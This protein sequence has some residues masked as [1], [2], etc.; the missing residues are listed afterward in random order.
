MEHVWVEAFV[1]FYPMRGAKHITGQ[2]DSWIPLDASFKQ[3]SYTQG[4]DIKSAV[5]FD[6]QIFVNQ[7]QS[8]ATI[9]TAN[10]SVT[11]INSTYIQQQMQSY[12]N[13]VKAYIEQNYPN[14]TVG[15]VLGKK[16]IIKQNFTY[17]LG[18]LPYQKSIVGIRYSEIPDNLRHKIT[19]KVT[20]DIYDE[21]SGTAINITKR[22]P[23]IAGKKIT[24]SYSPA[25]AQ[26][27]ATI[28]SYQPKPHA[29]GSPI[30]PSELLVSL[31]AYLINLKP[32]L[33]IDGEI[34]ATGT[35]VGMGYEETFEMV[36]TAPGF[37]T[38]IV[39]NQ[40]DAGA[41]HAIAI[42]TGKISKTQM[43]SLKTKME[44]INY[45][46]VVNLTRDNLL[47]DLLYA[48]ALM[49]YAQLDTANSIQSKA[50]SI[51]WNRLPSE[52]I[53]SVGLKVGMMF[54]L[55]R[56]ASAA[57]LVMDVDRNLHVAIARDGDKNTALNFMYASG[58]TSS[59]LEHAVPEKLFSTEDNPVIGISAVKAIKLANDQGIPIYTINQSNINTSLPQLQVDAEVKTEIQNAV[60]AGKEVT[61]SKTN[62]T[63]NNWTGCGYIIIDPSTG[64]GA[65]KISGGFNG[66]C[67]LLAYFCIALLAFALLWAF[68]GFWAFVLI[69]VMISFIQVFVSRM[70]K[71]WDDNPFTAT[72][73]LTMLLD[74]TVQISLG[75]AAFPPG[76]ASGL[77]NTILIVQAQLVDA[78]IFFFTKFKLLETYL[79]RLYAKEGM[80]IV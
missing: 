32:E 3:Y 44:Q 21:D 52:S 41:Y 33:R 45:N 65:Y 27:E 50:M 15:D 55:P 7:I 20:K 46:D 77:L 19:F 31:P 4:I 59:A 75:S 2:G 58:K 34:V 72:T 66:A 12:Q 23:E 63:V 5:P 79:A 57:A 17:L 76:F 62:I 16:E 53:F 48:T 74:I 36:F 24:L 11:N 39:S 14:A 67:L 26:D 1:K 73:A 80:A 18:T 42:N 28:N 43:L 60:N 35:T 6:A 70:I 68:P 71:G 40:I 30:Q 29:D 54:G 64:A 10:S 47:G 56:T 49:Y 9:D 22:L 61:V 69:N 51:V 25:T 8:T 37:A 78:F 38:D 13:Q